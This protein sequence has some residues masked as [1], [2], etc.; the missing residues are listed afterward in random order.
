MPEPIDLL[1]RPVYGMAQVDWVLGLRSGTARRWID[2]YERRGIDYPRVVRLEATGDEVVTWGE[3]TE[4][5]LL[6]EF[7]DQGVPVQ[8]MRPAVERL[9]EIFNTAYPLAHGRPWID[10]AGKELVLR[11]QEE[12][13]LDRKLLLVVVRNDQLMLTLPTEHFVESAE[14]D[15]RG[16]V[17]RLRP[18]TELESVWLD[19]LRQFGEPVVRSVPTEVIAEQV[20]AGD[21]PAHIAELYELSEADVLQAI[22]YELIR[23]R[24]AKPAA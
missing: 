20:R 7:R 19:P 13:D 9:R 15:E 10:A 21:T 16:V 2:G 22:R 11:V 18:M 1:A 6:A 4:A 12:V 5:R 24:D 23:G 14:F 17:R 8:R 3:F